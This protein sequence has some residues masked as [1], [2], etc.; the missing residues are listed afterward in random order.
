MPGQHSGKPLDGSW[1]CA[2][3]QVPTHRR[4]GPLLQFKDDRTADWDGLV[5]RA[6]SSMDPNGDG[7]ITAQ[8]LELLLCGEDG[9]EV[10]R[11]AAAALT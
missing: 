7:V 11:Q 6:F 3:C 4:P 9:C 10:G 8:E 1:A 5:K 2:C